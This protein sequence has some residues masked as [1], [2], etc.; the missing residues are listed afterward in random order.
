MSICHIKMRGRIKRALDRSLNNRALD[1]GVTK[2][3]T[4]CLT[5]VV[6]L[7]G[8]V[9]VGRAEAAPVKLILSNHFG[10]EVNLTEAKAGHALEDACTTA[11]GDQC[12]PGKESGEAGGFAFP[13]GVAAE[14]AGPRP[15]DV[16]V[17][18]LVNNRVQELTA[19]GVFVAMFG[20]QV[21]RTK[22]EAV[23]ALEAKGGK[24]TKQE[25]EEE[26][27]C[28][29]AS[30]DTCT[31]GV[32]GPGAGQ[33]AIPNSVA[34][35]PASG[36]V[37]VNEGGSYRVDEY[38]PDG[39]FVWMVGREVDQTKDKTQGAN[40]AER[41]L[42]TAASGDVCTRGVQ[43]PAGSTEHAAFSYAARG[44]VL[45]AG[46]PQDLLYVG[47][48][49]R[50]QELKAD[51]TW[52]REIPL[53][54]C[55]VAALAVDATGDVYLACTSANA[56][57][58]LDPNGQPITELPVTPSEQHA[59]IEVGTLALDSSGHLAVSALESG[60]SLTRWFG[61]LYDAGTGHRLTE[62]VG[63]GP[64]GIAFDSSGDLYAA[65]SP[66]S[67]TGTGHEVLVY[68]PVSVA[69]LVIKPV[70][71]KTGAEHETSVTFDCALNGEANPYGVAGTEVGFEWG[72]TCSLGS[73]TPKQGVPQQG[74]PPG[75]TLVPVEATIEG[76]RPNEA[77]CYQLVGYDENVQPPELLT[78][79]KLSF[80]TPLVAPAIVGGPSVS[81]VKSSSAVMLDELNPENAATEYFL[82]YATGETL[83]K[84]P[85]GMRNENCEEGVMATPAEQ[86]PCSV[87]GGVTRCVYGKIGVTL[88]A[89]GL[90]P[91]GTYHYRL[92]AESTNRAGTEK[93]ASLPGPE[94]SFTTA[95]AP[96]QQ[97]NTG[98]ASAVRATSAIVSG[99]V[100]PDGLPATYT[101][102]LGV[103]NGATTQ[104]GIVFSG[105][106]GTSTTPVEETL[107]LT[108][109]Q[110]GTTYAYRIAITSGYIKNE[111]HT[112]QGE[113]KTFPT[114]G[115]PEVLPEASVLAQLPTP[116]IT[117]PKTPAKVTPKKL[118]RAQQL[119]RA[120]KA[121][122]KK[123]KNRR[124]VCRHNA[125]AE[126]AASRK[127]HKSSP[128][129]KETH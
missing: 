85:H 127:A 7:A 82:E 96:V 94:G 34:V 9:T 31:A 19:A 107:A 29:L 3:F 47:D 25:L 36:D 40:E 32:Q 88:E 80:N 57:R 21:N 83:A 99:T 78:S 115:L 45:A 98:L 43:A 59:S 89:S 103:Y 30:A 65:G 121:C 63:S 5:G 22:V 116:P 102:E 73:K 124:A 104:Y 49:H 39:R 48:E 24:P 95:P 67:I 64:E 125:H 15:G 66:N 129:R 58:E 16:Y 93:Q 28:T 91:A 126:Y 12:Q 17:A 74:V 114:A 56:V 14:T 79:E 61:S 55:Q 46:G 119:A 110:P 2:L 37:Y 84:C 42:C 41:N 87:A 27:I 109:L 4:L 128:H 113:T 70:L 44:N 60:S 20:G 90:Q 81:L 54:G 123:P 86:A 101:F 76:L 51:G 8:V 106:A 35:D 111:S 75:N 77:F 62:F 18:D 53:A 13:G 10:R 11:S 100:N 122:T 108:G 120:L 38:T 50:V 1:R 69:E 97:A 52:V 71:C 92:Y 26:D 117:F 118:T 33:L 105:P 72:S 6:G 68:K 112:I 23:K